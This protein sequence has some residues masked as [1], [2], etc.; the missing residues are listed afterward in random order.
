MNSKNR[1][2]GQWEGTFTKEFYYR[3]MLMSLIERKQRSPI[4][5]EEQTLGMGHHQTASVGT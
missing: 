5:G 3:L 1:I 2:C 4:M